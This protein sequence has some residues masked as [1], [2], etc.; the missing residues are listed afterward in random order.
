MHRFLSLYN[1]Y[2]SAPAFVRDGGRSLER[3]SFP[4]NW[5]LNGFLIDLSTDFILFYFFFCAVH[6][7]NYLSESKADFSY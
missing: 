3:H 7:Q 1:T 6:F 4:Q 5:P 2:Q